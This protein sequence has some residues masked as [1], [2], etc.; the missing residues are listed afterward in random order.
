MYRERQHDCASCPMSSCD[1]SN[2]HLEHDDQ[3]ILV[4]ATLVDL[5]HHNVAHAFKQRI[6]TDA[7]YSNHQHND[8]SCNVDSND[9]VLPGDSFTPRQCHVLCIHLQK[10]KWHERVTQAIRECPHSSVGD[11]PA[12]GAS[13]ALLWCKKAI[14]CAPS[15]APLNE[16]DNRLNHQCSRQP[17]SHFHRKPF[18]AHREFKPSCHDICS[19][20][21]DLLIV[22]LHALMNVHLMASILKAMH[23]MLNLCVLLVCQR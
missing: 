7:I 14:G 18:Q 4:H 8:Q 22:M 23:M 20:G 6:L 17:A 2:T 16:S 13:V 15:A 19:C 11:S 3:E 12:L 5:I 1:A 21:D 9:A 10:S